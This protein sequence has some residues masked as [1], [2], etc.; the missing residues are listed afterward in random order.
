MRPS[1]STAV[2]CAGAVLAVVLGACAARDRPP[3]AGLP[4]RVA[5]SGDYAPFSLMRDQRLSGLDID[6]AQRLARDL[7]R[8]LDLV[9]IRWADLDDAIA[10]DR[11]DIAMG[12]VTMR[13]DRAL[14]GAYT[15][16]YA[17]VR[18]V[19]LVRAADARRFAAAPDLDRP[20]VRIAVNA[21]GHLERLAR[22]LFPHAAV[23][24]SDDNQSVPDRVR[25]GRADAALTDS[26]EATR[27]AAAELRAVGPFRTDYKA[28]LLP[29]SAD[30]LAETLDR[31]LAAREADGWLNEER[32]RWLGAG[33][34][35]AAA[36]DRESVA[37]FVRVRLDVMP[38]IAA[39]KR[40]AGLPIED[41]AQE[42]RVIE[43]VRRAAADPDYA[44]TVYRRLITLAK[45][46]QDAAAEPPVTVSLESLRAALGR[47]DR[48]LLRALDTAPR[49]TAAE[50]MAAL[51]PAIDAPGVSSGDV[52][53]LADA[54]ARR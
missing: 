1:R 13:A 12:G 32:A 15:R 3:P 30:T 4:L 11:V 52:E 33:R 5:T 45:V 20:D 42:A 2:R 14:R 51:R 7:G 16:P 34:I 23:R 9:R 41:S 50:W 53:R 17:T 38:A 40:S 6:I 26:A 24:P 37:A 31:W 46:V 18:V 35:E 29:P 36:A 25:D 44:E 10:Q 21:G 28:Y 49:S 8:P 43:R 48:S 54:L 22:T 19:A 47:I 39:A 27:W